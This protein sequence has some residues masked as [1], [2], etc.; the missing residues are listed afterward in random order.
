MVLETSLRKVKVV[1]VADNMRWWFQVQAIG[2]AM[3]LRLPSIYTELHSRESIE[4]HGAILHQRHDTGACCMLGLSSAV[5]IPG[6]TPR[7]DRDTVSYGGDTISGGAGYEVPT[8]SEDSSS[9]YA[10]LI[11]MPVVRSRHGGNS[12]ALLL[13]FLPSCIFVTLHAGMPLF[14]GSMLCSLLYL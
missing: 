6:E 10:T 1:H 13:A 7:Q 14:V 8:G 3:N 5:S 11:R 2:Q 9:L 4:D 12:S